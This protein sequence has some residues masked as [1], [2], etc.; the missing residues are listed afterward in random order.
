MKLKIITTCLC[1]LI[2]ITSFSQTVDLSSL[3]QEMTDVNSVAKWPDPYY[4]EMM[5]SSYDR[6]LVYTGK[7][8]PIK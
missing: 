2:S 1:C 6:N 7:V 8:K 3:L 4:T 5:S